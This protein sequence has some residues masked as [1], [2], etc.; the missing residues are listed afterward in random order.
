MYVVPSSISSNDEI[1]SWYSLESH[2]QCPVGA[3][4]GS[5]GCA[6]QEVALLKTV[7][8]SCLLSHGMKATCT[9]DKQVFGGVPFPYSSNLLYK[10]FASSDFQLGGCPAV[11]AQQLATLAPTRKTKISIEEKQH[12]DFFATF[13][14]TFT[15]KY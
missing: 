3:P 14:F 15:N 2:S 4:L 12:K 8:I 1:G 11:P 9:K 10:A 6:W 5:G 7:N 13:P